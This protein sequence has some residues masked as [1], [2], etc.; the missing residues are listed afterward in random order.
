[1]KDTTHT[2]VVVESVP[3]SYLTL[4][5]PMDCSPLGTPSLGLS[6]QEYYSRLPFPPPGDLPDLMSS[7]LAGGLYH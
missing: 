6:K 2:I 1:M 4:C 5:D 3:K 7:A